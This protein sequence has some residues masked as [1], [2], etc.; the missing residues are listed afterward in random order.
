MENQ[1]AFYQSVS[2]SSAFPSLLCPPNRTTSPLA[3]PYPL[4]A[5]AERLAK[6]DFTVCT[7]NSKRMK[8]C[9][10][11][12]PSGN[13]PYAR[14][15]CSERYAWVAFP[16]R[17]DSLLRRQLRARL[18]HITH[19]ATNC[20]ACRCVCRCVSLCPSLCLSPCP[21]PCL[22]LCPLDSPVYCLFCL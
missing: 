7:A 1:Q 22:S 11:S 9:T 4:H 20:Y 14:G 19:C 6:T 18:D 8:A 16:P 3:Y 21:S 10:I 17:S 2:L 12:M 5:I 13:Y 15:R